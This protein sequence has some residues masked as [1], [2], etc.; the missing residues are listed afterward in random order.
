M[1]P[2]AEP[3]QNCLKHGCLQGPFPSL[4]LKSWN[5]QGYLYD[6]LQCQSAAARDT[7]FPFANLKTLWEVGES[8]GLQPAELQ[9]LAD[10]EARFGSPQMEEHGVVEDVRQGMQAIPGVHG[11]NHV[12]QHMQAVTL[13]DQGEHAQM[14]S[15][16]GAVP[17]QAV[18]IHAVDT[19]QPLAYE[20]LA[21]LQPSKPEPSYDPIDDII[22]EPNSQRPAI[23]PRDGGRVLQP[24]G[25]MGSDAAAADPVTSMPQSRTV[26]QPQAQAATQPMQQQHTARMLAADPILN[27]PVHVERSPAPEPVRAA[28]ATVEAASGLPQTQFI[29]PYDLFEAK[30]PASQSKGQATARTEVTRHVHAEASPAYSTPARPSPVNSTAVAP[31]GRG[32]GSQPAPQRTGVP[33]ADIQREELVKRQKEE[34][35][36]QAAAQANAFQEQQERERRAAWTA[37]PQPVPLRQIMEDEEC[38]AELEGGCAL[39]I[40]HVHL[41]SHVD[42]RVCHASVTCTALQHRPVI[43]FLRQSTCCHVQ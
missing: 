2:A 22:D 9:R 14:H 20:D 23:D 41:V 10:A 17:E 33:L 38:A 32:W 16:V 19:V 24:F 5:D 31:G 7:F 4:N 35:A 25:G 30:Q 42:G 27:I 18:D 11:I 29:S 6:D 3:G 1:L 21:P 13:E 15:W 26:Q 40:T 39:W 8:L 34:A 36:A 43:L 37:Q 28:L 12:E